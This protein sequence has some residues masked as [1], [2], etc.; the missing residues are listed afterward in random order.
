MKKALLILLAFALVFGLVFTGCPN[1]STS[2]PPT[3]DGKKGGNPGDPISL[4]G[5]TL[6]LKDNFEY[7][8]GYQG[9]V[10]KAELFPGGKITEGDEY[11]LK[12][13]F[14]VDREL[15]DDITV[16][17]V[18]RTDPAG[19]GDYWIPLSYDKDDD[20][21]EVGDDDAPAVAATPDEA[22]D[23]KEVTQ[24][25]TF[26]ALHSALSAATNANCIAFETQG[27][28]TP[29]TAN[30]GKKGP[31][32]IVFTEFVFVKGT[33]DDLEGA[34]PPPPGYEPNPVVSGQDYTVKLQGLTMKNAAAWTANY[35]NLWLDLSE[36]FPAAFD[37]MKYDKYTLKAKFFDADGVEITVANGLGQ[38]RFSKGNAYSGGEWLQGENKG[39]LGT[40]AS[41][42]VGIYDNELLITPTMLYV[43]NTSATVAFIEITEITFHWGSSRLVSVSVP[44]PLPVVP[45]TGGGTLFLTLDISNFNDTNWSWKANDQGEGYLK[46]R[47]SP[48]TTTS[49]KAETAGKFQIYW[50]SGTG[51]PIDNGIGNF[52][53]FSYNAGDGDGNGETRGIAQGNISALT[54]NAS[55]ELDLNTYNAGAVAKILFYK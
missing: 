40:A 35:Q 18:D 43:Q 6:E 36:A 55:N 39:N 38:S 22:K 48:A 37:I 9:L 2:R 54:L 12:I 41:A 19:G 29:G 4:P 13:V 15:E 20:G 47:I 27:E 14:T 16:G 28:G 34:E 31:V 21:W 7:G 33:P 32:K 44:D 23:K 10:E 1:G 45:P 50:V 24:I 49:I 42:N 46:G 26:K 11:A 5:F 3:D 30:S 52:A 51:Q 53:G 17:L 8:E 25:I